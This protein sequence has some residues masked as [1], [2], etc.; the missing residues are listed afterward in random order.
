MNTT[1]LP[2]DPVPAVSESDAPPAIAEIFT[3]IRTTLDSGVVNLIWRHLATMPGALE[4]VWTSVKP[5]YVEHA[6]ARAE[7]LRAQ[8]GLPSIPAFSHDTLESAGLDEDARASIRAILDSYH[9]TNA[10][11]LVC[12]SAFLSRFDDQR[13]S[14]A[15]TIPLDSRATVS[16]SRRVAL[17][18]LPVMSDLAPAVRRLVQELNGFGEDADTEL[19]ASMYRHLAYWPTYL[20]LA[21]TLLVPLHARGE[22]IGLVAAVRQKGEAHGR[23]LAQRLPST[24]PIA[25]VAP[26]FGAVRRFVRHPIARMTAICAI[27]REATL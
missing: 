25:E 3:D 10:L 17:P 16:A 22:L 14:V 23:E 9:H 20:S 4:W 2:R 8:L 21:R 7:Q 27:L 15:S 11:A 19:V 1:D 24:K 26:V 13:S 12:L 6:P 5:L 18:P